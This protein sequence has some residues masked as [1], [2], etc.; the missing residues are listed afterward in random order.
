MAIW[1]AL[2]DPSERIRNEVAIAYGER[3]SNLN[4]A[5]ALPALFET[6]LAR[7]MTH[8][9]LALTLTLAGYREQRLG[10]SADDAFVLAEVT[11]F[12]FVA[13]ETIREVIRDKR[14]IAL[15]EDS[16]RDDESEAV[17]CL[18]EYC[19]F[20]RQPTRAD[21]NYLCNALSCAVSEIN[22]SLGIVTEPVHDDYPKWFLM[23]IDTSM[24]WVNLFSL[25]AQHHVEAVRAWMA[26]HRHNDAP[27]VSS[28]SDEIPF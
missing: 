17:R 16:E 26:G 15:A 27:A 14:F 8:H 9:E 22:G 13:A 25:E 21:I 28:Q 6:L 4:S 12:L 10:R 19:V 18:A 5:A 2:F 3:I 11:P 7:G 20:L 1:K 23:A 24:P